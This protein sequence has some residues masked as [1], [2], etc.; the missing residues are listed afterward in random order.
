MEPISQF[1]FLSEVP[2]FPIDCH[3]YWLLKREKIP[4]IIIISAEI[5]VPEKDAEGAKVDQGRRMAV[6]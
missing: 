6:R 5:G 3:K 2:P 1:Q 4:I